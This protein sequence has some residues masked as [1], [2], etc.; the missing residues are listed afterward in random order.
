M[1]LYISLQINKQTITLIQ[2]IWKILNIGSFYWRD[3]AYTE[4]THMNLN[5]WLL[6]VLL[7]HNNIYCQKISPLPEQLQWRLSVTDSSTL[8]T[9]CSVSTVG[10]CLHSSSVKT[11]TACPHRRWRHILQNFLFD[12]VFFWKQYPYPHTHTHD[13]THTLY[14]SIPS[15]HAILTSRMISHP[16]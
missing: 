8:S 16:A 14:N 5:N 4:Y 15:C 1:Y 7:M 2:T 9:C 12:S 13:Y 11:L 6:F 3:S 10:S